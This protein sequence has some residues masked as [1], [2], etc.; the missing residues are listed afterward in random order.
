MKPDAN[1]IKSACP[2]VDE[3]LVAEHVSRLDDRYFEIFD[4]NEICNHLTGLS[5]LSPEHPV[6]VLLEDLG[7]SHVDCTVLGFDYPNLFSLLAGVL[8]GMGF[9][10]LY[11]NVFTYGSASLEELPK[12]KGRQFGSPRSIRKP[13]KRKIIDHFFGRIDTTLPFRSWAQEFRYTVEAVL[14]ELENGSGE[15]VVRAKQ[16]VNEMVV[17]KL[18]S[19]RFAANPVL[20][21]VEIDIDNVSGPYTRMKV[22]SED[23]I[24]FLYTL[25]AALSFNK[26]SIEQVKIRTTDGRIE[27]EIDFVDVRN[28]KIEDPN[29]LD[30]IRLSVLLTKQFTYFLEKAPDAHTALSRFGH[31]VEDVLRLP[32]EGKWLELLSNPETLKDLARLLGASTYLWE[33][34]IRLQYETLLPMLKPQMKGHSLSHPSKTLPHRLSEAL[35]GISD[36]G[37]QRKQ[38][39]AFKDREL[40]LIDLDYILETGMDFRAFS[41]KLTRLA[42]S[43]VNAAARLTYGHLVR[44]FGVPRTVGGIETEYAIMGLGKVGGTALGYASDIELLFVYSDNGRTDGDEP[45]E[46]SE[47]FDRFV[48]GIREFIQ[49]KRE[50]IFR[51][52]LRLRPYGND[53]PLAC[54]LES[55][56]R[57]YAKGGPAHAYER[58]ALVRLRTIGGN[59][60]LGSRL[61]RIR[62]QIVYV[63][64]SVDV[65]EVLKLR[66]KQCDV[67]VRGDYLNAKF[68]PGGLVD[69][70]YA[71][72]IL[73]VMYG[74]ELPSL[75]TAS[76]HEALCALSDEAL[77]TPQDAVRLL[78]AYGF[79]RKLINGLRMLRGSAEDLV[80]PSPGSEE[81]AHLA[82]RMG[83]ERGGA[84]GPAHQLRIHFETH[85]AA[86]RAF[87]ERHFGRES[88]PD[89]RVGGVAD[90]VL[91]E[92]PSADLRNRILE[93]SGFKDVERA[94]VNIRNLSGTGSRQDAFARLA[95]LAFDMLRNT[96]DPDMALNNLER[97][98]RMVASP[99]S[100]YRQLLSQ[101]MRLDVLLRILA[102]S[103]FL[104]DTVIRDPGLMDWLTVPKN[105]YET[106]KKADLEEELRI[107]RSAGPNQKEW[108]KEL[109]RLRTREL[110]RIG[111]RDMVFNVSTKVITHELSILAEALVRVA[112]ENVWETLQE[113]GRIPDDTLPPR[114]RLCVLALGKLGGDELN[115]SSDIDLLSVF[116]DSSPGGK[117]PAPPWAVKKDLFAL[118]VDRLRSDLSSHTDAGYA[119]RVD[120]R[121]RPYG[122][123][124]ELVPSLSS[125]VNYYRHKASPWEIQALLKLRPIAGDMR[126]GD[127]I[128]EQVRPIL[129]ERRDRD[130]VVASIEKLRKT[131]VKKL[132][133][134]LVSGTDVKT[135]LG[136]LRDI[137][138]LVQGLQL[139]Y[140]SDHPELLGGNSLTALDALCERGLLPQD[141]AS[142]LRED[143]LFL[144][145]VE[146]CLQIMEDRQIHAVPQRPEELTALAKRMLG[147][148]SDAEAFTAQLD[149]CLQRVQKAYREFLAGES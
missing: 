50:G 57:Y 30:Q 20:Y 43:V 110:L 51:L 143:Y 41:E 10:I 44:R 11:G 40:F 100:R 128:M 126:L 82:R 139:I 27:D 68:S 65:Q 119:Y 125:L 135:G 104:A 7:E 63:S 39:N 46:N 76:I 109:R 69:L 29:I 22:V 87:V 23:T 142:Q 84:L 101:P 138:F 91:S 3:A 130:A 141:V 81:F 144:R 53:G 145:R 58:L 103:Q 56:S 60:A 85:T 134:G 54:S 21:P 124:G 79:F 86:V 147:V 52:D 94:Y 90:L 122:R 32:K 64:D 78:E 36:V 123:S 72:Q 59:G 17:K 67:K 132:W 113:Q 12:R 38:L 47:F 15:A 116:D 92:D 108:L 19:R 4:V 9:N 42:E 25:T 148:N 70:E 34:F 127:R 131:A 31:L 71:V 99:E 26:I 6:E 140:A 66:K 96:P 61:E 73:Q 117:D 106:R 48:K 35:K 33:D 74:E 77:L 121:L 95:I 129:M 136:G 107:F 5:G 149:G 13:P 75:R 137:E 111:T 18:A 105:L 93:D 1:E 24:A 16:L 133:G 146:H 97:Y 88:L 83:Y 45:L 115:Y 118:A 98:M 8:A 80:V 114:E 102:G 28:R 37:R 120:L 55:F 62:D 89:V 14:L 49:A 2:E 112:L